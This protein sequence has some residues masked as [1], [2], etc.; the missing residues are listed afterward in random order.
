MLT[1]K[2]SEPPLRWSEPANPLPFE[3]YRD[4]E[5][6][7]LLTIYG[8]KG[9]PLVGKRNFFRLNL[10]VEVLKTFQYH[11][12]P[13]Q[14]FINRAAENADVINVKQECEIL[15]VSK[16]HLHEATKTCSRI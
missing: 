12:N 14:H 6:S 11:L 16:T 4:L 1:P 3:F 10:E 2:T 9:V 7:H 8:L 15:L 13:V 5:K